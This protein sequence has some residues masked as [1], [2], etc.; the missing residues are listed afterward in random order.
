MKE[1]D[2][3]SFIKQS[4]KS[5][6]DSFT[7][8]LMNEII[9]QSK[10]ETMTNWKIIVLYTSC[11]LIFILSFTVTIPE[12]RFLNY[13]IRFS[14]LIIPILSIPFILYEFYQLHEIRRKILRFRKSN[15]V[16][17][18]FISNGGIPASGFGET[19]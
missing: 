3:R 15:V 1:N 6:S 2:I 13:S 4:I 16:Q 19:N 9:A 18:V 17:H 12:I 5:P 7:D 10:T 8:V 11:F 14:P